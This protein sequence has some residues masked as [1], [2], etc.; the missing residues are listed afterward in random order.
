MRFLLAGSTAKLER[1]FLALVTGEPHPFANFGIVSDARDVASVRAVA[2]TLAECNAPSLIGFHE[3]VGGEV[4]AI[5]AT[6]GFGEPD[7][8]PVMAAEIEK[9]GATSLPAGYKFR[10]AG[11]EDA[12]AWTQVI[13][14]SFGF[15]KSV[16]ELLSPHR[17]PKNSDVEQAHFVAVF[18][19][20]RAVAAAGL[21]LDGQIAGIYSVGTVPSER[22]KGLGAHVTASAFRL[23]QDLGYKVGVLQSS[24]A[25]YPVYKRLGFRDLGSVP[26]YFRV[27]G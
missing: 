17:P 3:D 4:Q 14:E 21:Y 23:A 1:D 9:I 27:P 5:L 6:Q 16:A 22:G 7:P 11:H 26:L 12:E 25:G 24:T 10:I 20:T 19:G 18:Q 15:P 2:Q 8:M 13:V